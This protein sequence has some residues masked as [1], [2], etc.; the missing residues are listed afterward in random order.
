MTNFQRS[1]IGVVLILVIAFCGAFVVSEL[2][3]NFGRIDTTELGAFSLSDGSKRIIDKL[4]KPL[5]VKLFYS[6]D[7]VD[8]TGVDQL[9]ELNSLYYYVRDLLRAYEEYGDGRIAVEEF[10]PKPYSDAEEEA[11][12]LKISRFGQGES[13]FYFGLAVTSE[14]GAEQTV[15]S[16]FDPYKPQDRP[17][18]E[19]LVSEAIELAT[20]P[21]RKTLGVMSSLDIAAGDMDPMMRQMMAMQGQQVP[22]P[23]GIIEV[24]RRFYEVTTVEVT[25]EE[26]PPELD[27]LLVI[28]PKE[29]SDPTLYA[30]DQFVMR[31]GKLIAFVDPYAYAADP[32]PRDPR[33]PMGGGM[34]H[35]ASSS[36]NK[37]LTAWGIEVPENQL[38]GDRNLM[39]SLPS[40]RTPMPVVAFLDLKSQRDAGINPDE[41]VARGL[42]QENL[43]VFAAGAIKTTA[44]MPKGVEFTPILRST[45]EGAAFTFDPTELAAAMSGMMGPDWS[46][47][48]SAFAPGASAVA[49]AGRLSGVLPSA[50]PAGDPSSPEAD[51]ADTDESDGA[52]E[53]DESATT[54]EQPAEEQ[55]AD[56]AGETEAA[57]DSAEAEPAAEHRTSTG[58]PNSVVVIADVDMLTDALCF[59]RA[60]G[61]LIPR[62]ANPDFVVNV[63]DYVAGSTDLMSIRS[64]GT[65]TRGFSVVED[66]E[67]SAEIRT[68]EQVARINADIQKFESD[69]RGMQS[70][71]T[72]E[73]VGVLRGEAAQKERELERQ[74]RQKRREL[75]DVQRERSAQ[76]DSL[77]ARLRTLNILGVPMVVLAIGLG[78]A[79][80]QRQKRR[81]E[82]TGGTA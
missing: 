10:D 73:N 18:V 55:P 16:L 9:R 59:Q 39:Q 69:L 65:A 41:A 33:N 11:D 36:L 24:L 8:N 15:A 46:K 32:P 1:T 48:N 26:I 52:D 50:F 14:Y 82:V 31:G 21:A 13:G 78:L 4:Q 40:G 30:I 62:S 58:E 56:P 12:R 22:Q 29:L 49:S 19:Y 57:P 34:G 28:H 35:T 70:Q 2:T 43:L 6:K 53:A 45:T 72:E 63:A 79:L 66:I 54:E 80:R 77:G 51:E 60:L 7:F 27:T 68:Q 3:R 20:K 71:A 42:S 64:R 44:D 75:R 37:L 67:R 38:V 23:W 76:I 5:T 47:L 74:I 61:M 17:H 25:A 81:I